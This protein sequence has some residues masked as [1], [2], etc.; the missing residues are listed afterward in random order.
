[1][2][3]VSSVVGNDWGGVVSV[4][5]VVGHGGGVDNGGNSHGFADV[6]GGDS[7]TGGDGDEVL[8]IGTGDLG[9]DV[10]VLNLNGD[11]LDGGV[12]HAVLGGDITASVLHSGGDGVSDGG[13]DDGG[14]GNV[15]VG[16]GSDGVVSGVS[17]VG[18]DSVSVSVLSIGISVGLALVQA[19]S[20][21]GNGVGNRGVAEM[22]S[23]LLAEGHILNLLGFDSHHVADVLGGGDTVL[24][25][26]NL[27]GGDALGCRVGV[28]GRGGDMTVAV[29]QAVAVS[30]VSL[31]VG[32]GGGISRG[33]QEGEGKN[34]SVH[35]CTRDH[36]PRWIVELK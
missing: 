15:S 8:N 11:N 34:L 29:S 21:M 13:G 24:G 25:G 19:V 33:Q 14:G 12:I 16:E 4:S 27:V 31:G 36:F 32:V 22:I 7:F 10:A 17:V 30:G 9:D 35:D 2:S 3:G 6:G 20:V 5:S 23:G 1:V 26:E 28:V 18:G